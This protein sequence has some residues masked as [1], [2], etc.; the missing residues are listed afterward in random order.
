MLIGAS[1]V[2]VKKGSEK[3]HLSLPHYGSLEG[4]LFTGDSER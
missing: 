4:G 1:R 2:Y 3:G